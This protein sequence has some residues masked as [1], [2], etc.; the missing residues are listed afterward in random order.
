[1]EKKYKL[2]DQTV[3]FD[4]KILYRIEAL[5]DF[6][7]VKTGDLGGFVESEHNLSHEGMCWIY[8]EAKVY[9]NARIEDDASVLDYAIVRDNAIVRHG[10]TVENQAYIAGNALV[11][12]EVAVF[13]K[14]II[15]NNA[16]LFD[17]VCVYGEAIIKDDAKVYGYARICGD[18]FVKGECNVRGDSCIGGTS[19]IDGRCVL[20]DVNVEG[21]VYINSDGHFNNASFNGDIFIK[22]IAIRANIDLSGDYYLGIDDFEIIHVPEKKFDIIYTKED[23]KWHANGFTYTKANDLITSM[24]FHP[25]TIKR[26]RSVENNVFSRIKRFL[27]SIF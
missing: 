25:N 12:M 5:K 19:F 9:A 10:A 1:M 2:T 8:D 21:S 15:T 27:K 6:G 23:G 14:A 24:K 7:D 26:I 17:N 3:E 22:D 13:D 4:G 11:S 20:T 18:A 16:E